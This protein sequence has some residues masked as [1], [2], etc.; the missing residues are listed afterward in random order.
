MQSRL[1]LQICNGG[2][3]KNK[4][5]FVKPKDMVIYT[6][7]RRYYTSIKMYRQVWKQDP[8]TKVS[9]ASSQYY[10]THEEWDEN[11]DNDEAK[12]ILP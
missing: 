2:I 1:A 4:D 9:L 10:Q 7:P 11:L 8:Q 12:Q 5:E 3:G 6:D